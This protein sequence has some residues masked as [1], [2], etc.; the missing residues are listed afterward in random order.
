MAVGR[1]SPL[2][3]QLLTRGSSPSCC[4][5]FLNSSPTHVC[6][7]LSCAHAP[8]KDTNTEAYIQ[9]MSALRQ[10]P[11]KLG[12]TE[13]SGLITKTSLEKT[14]RL[15]DSWIARLGEP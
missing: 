15:N 10:A 1:R 3:P 5:I 8:Y 6:A 11:R 7:R 4:Q 2:A 13:M 12:R 9:C 14:Y